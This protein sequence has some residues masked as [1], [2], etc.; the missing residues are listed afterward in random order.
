M[1]LECFGSLGGI[2]CIRN[3]TA[4]CFGLNCLT[5]GNVTTRVDVVVMFL[6]GHPN[7]M[8]GAGGARYFP[9]TQTATSGLLHTAGPSHGVGGGVCDRRAASSAVRLV[10]TE[11]PLLHQGDSNLGRGDWV[12]VSASPGAASAENEGFG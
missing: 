3:R 4:F 8:R 7:C 1:E 5:P 10:A 2:A 12:G 6:Q 9:S 11:P